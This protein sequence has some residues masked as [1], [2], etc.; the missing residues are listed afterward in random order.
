MQL[1]PLH[2]CVVVCQIEAEEKSAGGIIIPDTAQDKPQ[3][4]EVVAIAPS[5]RNQKG[6]LIALDVEVGDRVLFGIWSGTEVMVE[7]ENLLIVK[8]SD[9]LGIF[10]QIS[11]LEKAAQTPLIVS[12]RSVTK[13]QKEESPWLPRT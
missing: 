2:D 12:T 5:S 7:G 6:Q 9:F 3:E 11:T 10:E 1:R 4:G 13:T 8:E